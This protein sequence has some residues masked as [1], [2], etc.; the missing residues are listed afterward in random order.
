MGDLKAE[1]GEE[2]AQAARCSHT[3]SVH[4][5]HHFFDA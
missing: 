3:Q 1:G 5:N 2:V 4:L